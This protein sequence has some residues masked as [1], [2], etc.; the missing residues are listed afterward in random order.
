[1]NAS[2]TLQED[3]AAAL[4]SLRHRYSEFLPRVEDILGLVASD[5]T[6]T[7]LEY[8]EIFYDPVDVV[9]DSGK[10]VRVGVSEEVEL[11]WPLPPPYV[12]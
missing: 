4:D 1:M 3:V 8:L 10:P 12:Y 7:L 5:V 9:L 6:V 11:V 2:V